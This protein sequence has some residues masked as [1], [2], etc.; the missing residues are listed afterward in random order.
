MRGYKMKYLLSI[1]ILIAFITFN[2]II[3]N[4][5]D[6]PLVSKMWGATI[7][8]IEGINTSKAMAVGEVKYQNAKEYC[9]R[10]PGGETKQY[11]GKLTKEQCIQKVLREEEGKIHYLSADC[12]TR[13]LANDFGSFTLIGQTSDNVNIWRDNTSGKILEP[14]SANNTDVIDAQFKLLCPTCNIPFSNRK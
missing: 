10:D 11:G 7:I 12:K 2:N 3:A 6:F 9:D 13:T 5:K 8:K 14:C 1:I 4:A